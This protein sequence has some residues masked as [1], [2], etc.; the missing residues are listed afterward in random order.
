MAVG[1]MY[2][3]SLRHDDDHQPVILIGAS[4]CMQQIFP[5]VHFGVHFY[6]VNQTG[7]NYECIGDDPDMARTGT[8]E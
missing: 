4:V 8:D 7:L 1:R 5:W 6:D 3:V 2:C